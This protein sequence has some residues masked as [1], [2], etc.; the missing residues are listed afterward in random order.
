MFAFYR[1]QSTVIFFA[2]PEDNY[3]PFK[4]EATQSQRGSVSFAQDH[5]AGNGRVEAW[6]PIV[7]FQSNILSYLFIRAQKAN[8]LSDYNEG[9]APCTLASGTKVSGIIW[10]ITRPQTEL[11]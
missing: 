5:T 11:P 1:F 6:S 2:S 8:N 10:A 4:D 3:P 7:W 9:R